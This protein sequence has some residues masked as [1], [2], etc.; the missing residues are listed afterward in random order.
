MTGLTDPQDVLAWSHQQGAKMVALKMGARG[1]LV[2]TAAGVEFVAPYEVNALDA[3][4]AGDCYA[5][6]VLARLSAGDSIAIAARAGNVAAALS[7]LGYGALAPLPR[8]RD[9][10]ALL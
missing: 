9:V 8:W 5:G 3:T 10:Q 2:S 1:S 4:G 7:T 6:A